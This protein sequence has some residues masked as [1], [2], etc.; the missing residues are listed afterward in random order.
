MS[1]ASTFSLQEKHPRLPIP[2]LKDSCSLYLHSLR[3]LQT[4]AEHEKSKAIIY[5]FMNSPL[6]ESLQQRL[7]DIDRHSSTNWLDDIWLK[8]AY[9]ECRA[10]LMVNCNWFSIGKDD[11]DHPKGLLADNGRAFPAKSFSHFQIR[12]AATLAYNGGHFAEQL[13]KYDETLPIYT[14]REKT[15]LCMYQYTRLLSISRVPQLHCDELVQKDQSSILHIVVMAC[16]QVYT[17]NIFDLVNGKRN[18]LSVEQLEKALLVIASHASSQVNTQKHVP[19]LT[20]WDR[21]NWAVARNH[22]LTID[23]VGNRRSLSAIEDAL[24]VIC[25][26]DYSHGSDFQSCGDTAFCGNQMRGQGHNRWFDKPASFIVENNGKVMIMGEH[27]PLD[28]LVTDHFFDLT[29]TDSVTE[30]SASDSQGSRPPW[31]TDAPAPPG[32]SIELSHLVEHLTWTTD[33]TVNIY[34]QQAQ[35]VANDQS[36]LYKYDNLWF[37]DFGNDEVRKVTKLSPDALYQM[38]IQLTYYRAHGTITPTYE[39]AMTRVFRNGRT[40]TIRSCSVESK[41]FIEA[42]DDPEK[43]EKDTYELL[44]DAVMAHKKYIVMASTGKGCDR[45]LLALMLL[46]KDHMVRDPSSGQLVQASMHPIFS[47]PIFTNSQIFRLTTSGIE[48]DSNVIANGFYC[49]LGYGITYLTGPRFL[50]FGITSTNTKSTLPA[51]FFADALLRSLRDVFGLCK[52][53]NGLAIKDKSNL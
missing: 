37:D 32:E 36:Q 33:H 39:T 53:A 14:I 29:L 50:R 24:F 22:L 49:P 10:P 40:E 6:A 30:R 11:P 18:L 23:P 19:L 47:D 38:A 3:P 52:M 51:K 1:G 46:N 31:L 27:S 8:K 43:S 28:A 2:S 34:I 48:N 25:L 17:L 15:P 16:D 45:H 9:L 42:F 7:H 26:D 41:R 20:C 13:A 35:K 4:P 21:D 12:R 5:D 44:V